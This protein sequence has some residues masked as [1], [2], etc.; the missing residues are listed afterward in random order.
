MSILK[1][2][3]GSDFVSIPALVGPEGPKGEKGDQ[4]IQGMAGKDGTNIEVSTTE[5]IDTDV[6]VWINPSATSEVEDLSNNVQNIQTRMNTVEDEL[7]SVNA[8]LVSCLTTGDIYIINGTT[9]SAPDSSGNVQ[10]AAIPNDVFIIS[11]KPTSDVNIN[12]VPYQPGTSFNT[13]Y[14]HLVANFDSN[15][16][17]INYQALVFKPR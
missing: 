1:I 5:P 10:L 14:A 9:T 15:V 16:N 7:D 4:G 6:E 11:F 3:D 13:W 2:R 12:M 17:T 8:T